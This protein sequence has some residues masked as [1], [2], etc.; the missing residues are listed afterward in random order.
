MPFHGNLRSRRL[1]S[2]HYLVICG[3]MDLDDVPMGAVHNGMCHL[4]I[5]NKSAA[6]LKPKNTGWC[7]NALLMGE[8]H[9]FC[10]D[11]PLES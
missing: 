3:P 5:R 2:P 8:F 11:F 10:S 1:P 6:A 7:P 4:G 9:H